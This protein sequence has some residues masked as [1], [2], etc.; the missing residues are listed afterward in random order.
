MLD[1]QGWRKKT[2][3]IAPHGDA[4]RLAIAVVHA[5]AVALDSFSTGNQATSLPPRLAQLLGSDEVTWVSGLR[6]GARVAL[7]RWSAGPPMGGAARFTFVELFAGIGGFRVA[8]DEL[9]GRCVLASELEPHA[10]AT[11]EANFGEAPAGDITEI[12]SESVPAHDL[13][14]GGFPC[15]AFSRL[16]C[17]GGKPHI[18]VLLASEC[19]QPSCTRLCRTMLAPHLP[20]PPTLL[21]TWMCACIPLAAAPHPP[22]HLDVCRRVS[23]SPLL[24]SRPPCAPPPTSRSHP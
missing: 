12:P 21:P 11:Y 24:R 17:E 14:V 8:L 13:L 23:R 4:G 6:P 2:V 22:P 19:Q 5:G 9:G 15:Q 10:A 20:P 1:G 16:G 3:A 7:G 18:R